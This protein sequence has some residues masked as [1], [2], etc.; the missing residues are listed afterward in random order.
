[1]IFFD[2]INDNSPEIT[3]GL[4][5]QIP[6]FTGRDLGKAMQQPGIISI[7]LSARFLKFSN[8]CKSDVSS[9]SGASKKQSRVYI[10]PMA[11]SL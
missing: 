1:V 11:G 7:K 6:Q 2:S 8:Q 5:F 9:D 3:S 10:F 4:T